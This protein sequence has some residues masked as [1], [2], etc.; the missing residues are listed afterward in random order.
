MKSIIKETSTESFPYPK[1]MVACGAED[2]VVLFSKSEC[3]VVV[4]SASPSDGYEI[5][6]VSN[7][8]CMGN[9]E[10]F[11]G[12]VEL[13]NRR[14]KLKT[15]A[16]DLYGTKEKKFHPFKIEIEIENEQE[17]IGL[18]LRLNLSSKTVVEGNDLEGFRKGFSVDI[19]SSYHLDT[20]ELF[21]LVNSILSRKEYMK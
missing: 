14:L 3:G 10:H 15:A 8:W 18:W 11:N 13:S 16:K 4:A 9:F 1:L 19:P 6:H 7:D 17:L 20:V 5:G 21:R 12:I 2:F